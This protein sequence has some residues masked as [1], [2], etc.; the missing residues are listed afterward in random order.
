VQDTSGFVTVGIP[1]LLAFA[2]AATTLVPPL[3]RRVA[4]AGRAL[5]GILRATFF[6]FVGLSLGAALADPGH[7]SA[8]AWAARALAV[9]LGLGLVYWTQ[10]RGTKAQ[11]VPI[12]LLAVFGLAAVAVLWNFPVREWQAGAWVMLVGYVAALASEVAEL[13]PTPTFAHAG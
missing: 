11:R 2:Y 7:T 1:I 3:A 12:L 4:H 9:G 8:S 13:R 10:G 5:H 6:I